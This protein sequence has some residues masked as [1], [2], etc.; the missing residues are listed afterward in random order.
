M[1]VIGAG[2]GRTG[3]TSLQAALHQLGFTPCYHAGEVFANPDHTDYWVAAARGDSDGWRRALKGYRA[4]LDWPAV[5]FWRELAEAYPGAKIILTT[6]D[7]GSWF[8]SIDQTIF[9]TVTTGQV[10]PAVVQMFGGGDEKAAQLADVAATLAREVMIPRSFGGSIDDRDHVIACYERHN[11]EVRRE[12]PPS[13]LLDYEVGQG[14]EPLCAFLGVPIP[15][16]PF[17][18]VNDRGTLLADDQR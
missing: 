10:P 6:R 13:R 8:E 3:T 12:V 2:F 5:A 9:K 16:V 15:S 14:W 11:E 1:D 7:A 18:H 4:T 17:P